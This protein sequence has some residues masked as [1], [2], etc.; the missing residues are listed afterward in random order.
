MG[1]VRDEILSL[2]KRVFIISKTYSSIS[3][4]FAHWEDST[5]E[6]RQLDEVYYEYL[7]RAIATEG[8]YE[9]A[10]IMHEF[11]AR[12]NNA[13]SRYT[14]R[15]VSRSILP[16]GFTMRLIDG[17]W[18][19]HQSHTLDLCLGDVVQTI[20]GDSIET[21]ISRTNPYVR[22]KNE[23]ARQSEF[24]TLISWFLKEN[25]LEVTVLDASGEPRLVYIDRT[26]LPIG[27]S[28][29]TQGH[30]IKELDAGY[31]SVPSFN[32]PQFEE[33]ALDF[34]EQ[35][36]NSTSIIVDVR[37]NAGGVTPIY[38]MQRLLNVPWRWWTERSRHADWM[39]ERHG[40]SGCRQLAVDGS[41]IE[42]VR[43]VE[44][45]VP[46]A[47]EGNVIVLTDRYTHS[48]AED[49]TMALKMN[50]RAVVIGEQT[51]GSTGMPYMYSF[52]DDIQVA[53]G[54]IRCYLPGGIPFEGIGIKPDM[55]V[56]KTK[57]DY[58]EQRDPIYDAA[59]KFIRT[60]Q[61]Y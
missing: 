42:F 39:F 35:Y 14:D 57:R 7:Q 10:L 52:D 29:E 19:V 37:G 23:V 21:W 25:I 6:S 46:G 51:A 38:L 32:A 12:L 3:T 30:F 60:K 9:F 2:E 8:R 17:E 18:V 34:Y 43:H 24:Q 16:I 4:Y 26:T 50:D 55:A 54:S 5:F 40:T 33:R 44:M 58:I 28:F 22:A 47:F 36:Q 27:Y 15:K 1:F 53:I 59:L 11:I 48:A 49:F 31:I 56:A 13:H 20:Q 41:Y 45:P 61:D